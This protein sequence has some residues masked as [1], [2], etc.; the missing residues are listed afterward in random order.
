MAILKSIREAFISYDANIL[1]SSTLHPQSGNY[2]VLAS[3]PIYFS[4]KGSSFG[5]DFL[6]LAFV[7]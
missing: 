7:N 2:I 3:G 4:K 1:A 5:H 6:S